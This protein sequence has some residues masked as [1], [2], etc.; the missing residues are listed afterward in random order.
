[1]SS[2]ASGSSTRTVDRGGRGV[3]RLHR[4]T[5]AP[6]A[7]I[8]DGFIAHS[9]AGAPH[10][11]DA[12]ALNNRSVMRR[13]VGDLA[14]AS[15]DSEKALELVRRGGDGQLIGLAMVG[16]AGALLDEGHTAEALALA[17]EALDLEN[18]VLNDFMVVEAVWVM[19]DLGLADDYLAWLAR[20]TGPAWG[21]AASLICSGDLAG[22]VDLL[23]KIRYRPGGAQARLRLARQLVEEGRRTEADVELQRSLAFWREV[24]ATRYVREGEELLA[25]SA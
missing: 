10:Y 14:G 21:R 15:A 24:G 25:A 9:E 20:K 12:V 7:P 11:L 4:R 8:L 6:G 5:L 1:M 16:R 2:E 17:R 13:P 22:A 3:D 19:V 23:E 18:L